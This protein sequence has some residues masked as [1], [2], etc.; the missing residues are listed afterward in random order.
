MAF[1]LI[2]AEAVVSGSLLGVYELA[3]EH[4]QSPDF[5]PGVSG[6]AI[7]G[8]G[9]AQF[10]NLDLTGTTFTGDNFM[11]TPAGEF[12]YNPAPG[13]AQLAS[14]NASAAGTDQ[15]GN[16]YLAGL[17]SY[18]EVSGIL[19]ATQVGDPGGS[20]AGVYLY[21]ATSAA[22]PWTAK[23]QIYTSNGQL[24]I[25]TLTAFPPVIG[26]LAAVA[27]NPSTGNPEAEHV[28]NFG[29]PP[30][31]IGNVSYRLLTTGAVL[32]EWTFA[33][34][35]G[36]AVTDGETILAAA[37]PAG[38]R[39]TTNPKFLA[40]VEHT[41]AGSAAATLQVNTSGDLIINAPPSSTVTSFAGTGSYTPAV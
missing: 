5:V 36:T 28:I 15:Y 21:E 37:I 14:S 40:G 8:D 6:W 30:G 26:P 7:F 39:P 18:S 25:K 19:Y 4:L 17:V 13:F 32:I 3:G 24:F 9:S 33:I 31:W 27:V 23:A 35:S 11:I 10:N 41:S 1:K 22:G 12:W 20:Q 16:A 34:S 38:W 29:F 2:P